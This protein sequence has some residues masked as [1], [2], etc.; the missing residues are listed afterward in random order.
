MPEFTHHEVSG[1]SKGY[2][3]TFTP[4]GT[5]HAV[6]STPGACSLQI[7]VPP[8]SFDE[9]LGM[10]NAVVGSKDRYMRKYAKTNKEHFGKGGSASITDYE[11]V[12]LSSWSCR[13]ELY[14]KDKIFLNRT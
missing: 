7:M 10:F 11:A 1:T 4:G 13:C 14:F 6:Q 2:G 12:Q 5:I 8:R 3:L 9:C